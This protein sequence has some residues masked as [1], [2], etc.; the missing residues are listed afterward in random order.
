MMQFKS[1]LIALAVLPGLG[2]LVRRNSVRV[3]GGGSWQR[4]RQQLEDAGYPAPVAHRHRRQLSCIRLS[5]AER[6]F[7]PGLPDMFDLY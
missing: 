2:F 4:G 1:T 5:Q 7:H 3:Y 6:C